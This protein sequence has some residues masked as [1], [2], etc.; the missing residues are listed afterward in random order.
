MDIERSNVDIG[1]VK[2]FAGITAIKKD[3]KTLNNPGQHLKLAIT[4]TKMTF[5]D[6]NVSDDEIYD[7]AEKDKDVKFFYVIPMSDLRGTP[8]FTSRLHIS[9]FE[10]TTREREAELCYQ[11]RSE[12]RQQSASLHGKGNF[13]C[14]QVGVF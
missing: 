9:V 5:F 8:L 1:S 6:A 13:L 14:A 10:G 3:K 11:N 7:I 4:S 2:I 12:V